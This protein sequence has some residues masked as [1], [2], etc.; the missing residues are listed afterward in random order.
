MTNAYEVDIQSEKQSFI[1]VE[2][3]LA[4]TKQELYD[5]NLELDNSKYEIEH[6][7]G[8]KKDFEE[9]RSFFIGDLDETKMK[10][11]VSIFTKTMSNRK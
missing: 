7:Q 6:L 8:I 9:Q 5:T 4:T 2:Q 10:G 3:T 11:N 1:Q